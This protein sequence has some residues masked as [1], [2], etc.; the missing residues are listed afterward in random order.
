M[1]Y[2]PPLSKV[3]RE[4][5]PSQDAHV[6]KGGDDYESPTAAKVSLRK[7]MRGVLTGLA[8]NTHRTE[9]AAICKAVAASS[10]F[11][12]ASSI[13]LYTPLPSEPD[14]WPLA[15]LAA[16]QGKR[17]YVPVVRNVS[18]PDMK[19]ER[20]AADQTGLDAWK[21][22]ERGPLGI[23]IAPRDLSTQVAHDDATGL[24]DAG[25][26][27]VLVP[28]I[29]FD[30]SGNRLGRGGG[31]YD[32]FMRAAPEHV[33]FCGVAFVSQVV[34]AVPVEALDC[35]VRLLATARGLLDCATI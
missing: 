26:S 25:E 14:C 34:Q 22:W 32:C 18:P 2:V 5:M 3:M 13:M 15:A 9:S 1:Q 30:G 4:P 35:K 28:G 12:S 19:A 6:I 11:A 10:Q 31:F 29:A 20:V 23:A 24:R 8:A 16:S 27:L 7:A 33:T 21:T 17:V